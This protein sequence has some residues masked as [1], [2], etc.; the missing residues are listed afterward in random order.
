MVTFVFTPKAFVG[1]SGMFTVTENVWKE[2]RK[3]YLSLEI[4]SALRSILVSL[5]DIYI[6][7]H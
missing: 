7:L 1:Y 6:S 5:S 4:V 3:G 2:V